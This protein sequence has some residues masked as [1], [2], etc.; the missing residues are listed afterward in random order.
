MQGRSGVGENLYTIIGD[1]GT[2]PS[3]ATGWAQ[4]IAAWYNE[5]HQYNYNSPGTSA[6]LPLL[7]F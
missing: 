3:V 5:I 6:A 4:G 2:L 7:A 1:P